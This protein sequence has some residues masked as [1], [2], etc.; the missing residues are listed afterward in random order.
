MAD[1][2]TPRDQEERRLRGNVPTVVQTADDFE[3]KRI[4]GT[5]ATLTTPLSRA[6]DAEEVRTANGAK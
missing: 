2:R 4:L 1:I 5:S 3:Y 6:R